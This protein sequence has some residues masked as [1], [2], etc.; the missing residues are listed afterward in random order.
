MITHILICIYVPNKNRIDIISGLTL[1]SPEMT[2]L[3]KYSVY[4]K[5]LDFDFCFEYM[6]LPMSF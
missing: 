6:S 4:C 2:A 5:K 1:N 3:T